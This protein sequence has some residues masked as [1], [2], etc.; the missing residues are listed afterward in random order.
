MKS[1]SLFLA[2]LSIV[3]LSACGGSGSG[4]DD[5]PNPPPIEQPPAPT[6]AVLSVTPSSIELIAKSD[7]PVTL[8]VANTSSDTTAT[9]ISAL[10]P[11]SWT[12]V[13]Q[14]A[15]GCTSLPPQ[16]Q[17]TLS[18][19]PGAASHPQATV[20]IKGSN[21]ETASATIVVSPPNGAV[22]VEL[23]ATTVSVEAGQTIMM[24]VQNTSATVTATN[25]SA[26]LAGTVL[27]G[28][29]TQDASG[30]IAVP[31]GAS[32]SLSFVAGNTPVS[33]TSFSI[34]GDNTSTIGGSIAIT[35]PI[36]AQLGIAGSPLVLQATAGTATAGTLTITNLST[37]VTAT[38]IYARFGGTALAGEITQDASNCTMLAPAQSC[39]LSFTPGAIAVPQTA[40]TIHGDNTSQVGASIAIDAPQAVLSVSGSPLELF[41]N[42]TAK[43]LAVTNISADRAENIAA[44]FTGTALDGNVVHDA[45]ACPLLLPSQSCLLTF[46]PGS[47]AVASTAFAIAGSNTNTLVANMTIT[48]LAVGDTFAGGIVMVLP[49]GNTPGLIVA[50]GELSLEWG[51]FSINTLATSATDGAANT[52]RIIDEIGNNS[53]TPYAAQY[54]NIFSQSV[55]A[56]TYDDWFLPARDQLAELI[57]AD[58]SESIG[59]F[60]NTYWSSSEVDAFTAGTMTSVAIGADSNKGSHRWVRCVRA[61]TL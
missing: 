57:T 8:T 45:S 20:N 22:I 54:C 46:T 56:V 17:C 61:F 12:D 4:G 13:V 27:A 10:L 16:A 3:L 35:V 34:R 41:A 11:A 15:S 30:C 19:T 25:I 21:T 1:T 23:T 7:A 33:S 44:N 26:R 2:A 28:N 32:C 52:A 24:M 49:S 47:T 18:F 42:G 55:G 39:T 5:A 53:G 29:V 50:M 37:D 36:T 60:S 51:G 9:S 31:P 43:T 38:N 40:F 59:I 14:D 48:A 6:N 58:I